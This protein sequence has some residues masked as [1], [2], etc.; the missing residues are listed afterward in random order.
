MIRSALSDSGPAGV[1]GSRARPETGTPLR[2][3]PPGES[4]PGTSSEARPRRL[5]PPPGGSDLPKR[6]LDEVREKRRDA[7]FH[8]IFAGPYRRSSW[9]DRASRRHNAASSSRPSSRRRERTRGSRLR[10]PLA[11]EPQ[12]H[13][14]LAQGRRANIPAASSIPPPGGRRASAYEGFGDALFKSSHVR[15][16]SRRPPDPQGEVVGVA[17]L[18]ESLV[19]GDEPLL[20]EVRMDWSKVCIRSSR[21]PARSPRGSCGSCP[22]PRYIPGSGRCSGGSPRR[23]RAPGRPRGEADAAKSPP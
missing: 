3:L 18:P 9:Y 8:A 6:L 15:S 21:T 11:R 7:S 23:E 12:G 10:R 20:E 5:R 22:C 19:K 13:L 1:G 2:P 17:G 4:L 16:E 14:S